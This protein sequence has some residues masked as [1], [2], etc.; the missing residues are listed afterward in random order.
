MKKILF[1]ISVT[2]LLLACSRE[3]H[4]HEQEAAA[5]IE[6]QQPESSSADDVN[7]TLNDG[8]KWKVNPEMMKH[9][10]AMEKDIQSFNGHSLEEY[11]T[12]AKKTNDHISEL[13]SSCTMT[14]R[15]HEELHK[16]LHPFMELS[17]Q[18]GNSESVASAAQHY[19]TIK[20]Q[21]E[22]FHQYFE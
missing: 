8:E 21:M 17:E 16:W 6:K 12:L 22:V 15:S 10:E 20:K 13:T 3:Q 18:F 7:I 2:S 11:K 19:E 14:G 1:L 5:P 9:V 4:V